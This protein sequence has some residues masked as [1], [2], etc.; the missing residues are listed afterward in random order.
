MHD[1]YGHFQGVV[2]TADILESIVGVFRTEHGP[3]EQPLVERSDGS[4]LV[5][6]W[7]P[8]DDFAARLGL[9]LPERRPYHTV[10]GFVLDG[11]G[12]LPKVGDTVD[13][14][15]WRFEVLD[16]D[17]RRIDKVLATRIVATRRAR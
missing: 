14:H 10:A 3:A 7:M 13:R 11:F 2:T 15:G 8:A 16:L 5:S 4:Y 17:G 1:E 6:G 9:P 12:R